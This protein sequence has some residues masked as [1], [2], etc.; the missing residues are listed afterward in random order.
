[1]R[2]RTAAIASIARLA[3]ASPQLRQFLLRILNRTPRLKRRLKHALGR[4][5]TIASQRTGARDDEPDDDALLSRAA[6][7]VLRDLRRERLRIDAGGGP[8]DRT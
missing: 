7:R 2:W 8:A 6:R 5:N 3:A 1:M 4:A